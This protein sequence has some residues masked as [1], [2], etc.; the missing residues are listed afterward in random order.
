VSVGGEM[1]ER[2]RAAGAYRTPPSTNTNTERAG[3]SHNVIPERLSESRH[4]R[5][6]ALLVA[7]TGTTCGQRP[8][9]LRL[10]HTATYTG[11]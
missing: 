9:A 10:A 7:I 6:S 3:I 1:E 4:P 11:K 2:N 8:L 5:T